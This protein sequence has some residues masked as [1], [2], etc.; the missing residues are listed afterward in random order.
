MRWSIPFT[1]TMRGRWPSLGGHCLHFEEVVGHYEEVT[2]P[3]MA[4]SLPLRRGGEDCHPLRFEEEDDHPL[5]LE[6]GGE[7]AYPL[8]LEEE[9]DNPLH[10]EEEVPIL[11]VAMSFTSK[12]V[13]HLLHLEEWM[14]IPFTCSRWSSSPSLLEGGWPSPS[15]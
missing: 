2:I 8:L 5:G 6:E 13:D 11:W 15:L 1:F 14:F 4:I 10:Y 12:E 7:R 9:G 3:W